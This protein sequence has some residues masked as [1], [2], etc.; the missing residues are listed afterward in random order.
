METD[1]SSFAAVIGC[2]E[3]SEGL[4]NYSNLPVMTSVDPARAARVIF[5]LPCEDSRTALAPFSERIRKLDSYA[6]GGLLPA[7]PNERKWLMDFRIESMRMAASSDSNI[8][9]AQIRNLLSWHLS[10]LDQ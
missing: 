3:R 7:W 6:T 8:R 5:G 4:Q 9:A 1:A 2:G 10:F